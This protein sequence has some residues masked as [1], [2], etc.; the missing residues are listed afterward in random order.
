MPTSV[1]P[2]ARSHAP[3]GNAMEVSAQSASVPLPPGEGRVRGT[4]QGA[5]PVPAALTPALS[6]RERERGVGAG[7]EARVGFMVLLLATAL[8]VAGVLEAQK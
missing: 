6:R 7:V 3:C 8:C 4:R 1:A 5:R 2:L